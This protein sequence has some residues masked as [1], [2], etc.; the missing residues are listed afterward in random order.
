MVEEMEERHTR[1]Q[2]DRAMFSTLSAHENHLESF[3]NSTPGG[4]GWLG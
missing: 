4:T 1:G 3:Q 2:A